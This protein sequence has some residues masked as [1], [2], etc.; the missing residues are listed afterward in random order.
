MISSRILR[1]ICMRL[2]VVPVAFFELR[3][4]GSSMEQQ[5]DMEKVTSRHQMLCWPQQ[6]YTMQLKIR[7]KLSS[8]S[9]DR[10]STSTPL[11]VTCRKHFSRTGLARSS[12]P[13]DLDGS[14]MLRTEQHQPGHLSA[15]TRRG[16]TQRLVATVYVHFTLF[17]SLIR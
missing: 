17:F 13:Q 9:G 1:W 3:L 4:I 14:H 12:C 8:D 7:V 10:I 16:Q 5:A 15:L 11:S 6:R 2:V